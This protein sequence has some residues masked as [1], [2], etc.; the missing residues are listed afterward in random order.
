MTHILVAGSRPMNYRATMKSLN[1]RFLDRCLVSKPSSPSTCPVSRSVSRSP[2]LPT[3]FSAKVAS[4]NSASSLH[5]RRARSPTSDAAIRTR[6]GLSSAA[7]DSPGLFGVMGLHTPRD[8]EA[9]A[10]RSIAHVLDLCQVRRSSRGALA[11]AA[12]PALLPVLRR[13]PPRSASPP[14]RCSTCST[15]CPTQFAWSWT[16]PSSA[17]IPPSLP[18]RLLLRPP[19]LLPPHPRATP[20]LRPPSAPRPRPHARA[21]AGAYTRTRPWRAR[22]TRRTRAWGS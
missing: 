6:R 20:P 9:L 17:G 12:E 19:P 22:R 21:A 2:P 16:W 7:A 14:R 4:C 13:R 8:F 1:V 5:S 15:A 18:A 10:D 11:P 3:P